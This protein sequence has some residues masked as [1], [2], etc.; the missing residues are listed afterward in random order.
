MNNSDVQPNTN[1]Y[2]QY[3]KSPVEQVHVNR[4]PQ[5]NQ[6]ADIEASDY[7]NQVARINE[8]IDISMGYRESGNQYYELNEGGTQKK[9]RK[10]KAKERLSG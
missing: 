7:S 8:Q 6:M 9:E 10:R 1:I 2:S 3:V 5:Q 4:E